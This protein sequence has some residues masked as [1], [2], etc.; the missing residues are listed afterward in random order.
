MAADRP[1]HANRA[2]IVTTHRAEV[3]E[4]RGTCSGCGRWC[5]GEGTKKKD[6]QQPFDGLTNRGRYRLCPT[7]LKWL[8]RRGGNSLRDDQI[9]ERM[10]QLRAK[11][12]Y[13]LDDA[14]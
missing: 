5:T 14:S 4:G 7:D 11:R 10:I 2:E 9:D 13:S 3:R 12:G 1:S 8:D 6:R